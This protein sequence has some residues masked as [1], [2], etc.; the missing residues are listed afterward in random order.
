VRYDPATVPTRLAQLRSLAGL[1]AG[2]AKALAV[3]GSGRAYPRVDGG[4]EV[5]GL[6][7]RATIT[8]DRFG[9]PHVEAASEADAIFGQGFVQAQDRLFQLEL[10]R[11]AAA[12]RLAEVLGPSAL[13]PDRFMR[14]LGIAG[15]AADDLTSSSAEE[16][17]LLDAFAAGVNAAVATRRA[18]P[19]EFAVLGVAPEPWRPEHS[20]LVGRLLMLG[21]AMNWDGELERDR[22][23]A[24]LGPE[25]A[26]LVDA[27]YRPDAATT[28]GDPNEGAAE[29]LLVAYR[30]VASA[31]VLAGGASNAWAVTGEHTRSG[32]PLLACDP[33]LRAG[34]PGLFHVAHLVGGELDVI[35]AGVP[36]LPGV[37]IGHNR[38]VAW[39]V[40]AGLADVSD[41]YIEEID[42]DDP[43]RYRT[44]GGWERARTRVERIEVRGASAVE[45][46]VIET[47]HGAVIG[48]AIPGEERAIALR[49]TALEDGEMAAPLLDANRARDAAEFDAAIA[50]WPG[51][52]FNFVFAD[53]E[54]SIGYR[55]GG[56]IPRRERGEG[57]LPQDGAR[58]PGPRE[59]LATEEMPQLR[60]P[61]CGVVVSANQAPGGPHELGEEW[62]EPYRAERIT[63]LLALRND[64]TVASMQAIQLDLHNAALVA[65]RDL[66]L[67]RDAVEDPEARAILE[68]WEGQSDTASAGAAI[69]QTVYQEAAR[70]LVARVA[71]DAADFVLGKGLGAP[72]GEQSR[73]HYRLQGRIV[74]ALAE[75][76]APWCDDAADRDRVLR[77]AVARAVDELR[78]RLG[79][80]PAAWRWGALREQRRPHPL[81]RVPSLGRAFAVGPFEMPGDINTVW[82]GG[83]AVHAGAA[84]PGGFSPVYRQVLDLG[85][86][87]RSSFQLPAGNSG[88]PGHPHYEDCVDEFLEGRQRPLLYSREAVRVNAAHTLVLDPAGAPS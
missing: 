63:E 65:L 36:G 52:T 53:R 33:H 17:A 8:R 28:T 16:R 58:S 78:E 57:L 83:Y 29:R 80:R 5:D 55:M 45:E 54:G 18:L 48:P 43:A 38:D 2:V 19:P 7:R 69:M 26:A 84:A 59:P 82:Q 73:F 31:G 79:R 15:R 74:A 37:V 34:V 50:R 60:D 24:A 30:G 61:P 42:P 86:W 27:A 6:E 62:T 22:L 20:M 13:E 70:T 40:T 76:G 68:V 11:R 35:G 67:A 81:D 77:A 88:I 3:A 41:C 56:S 10:F 49:S 9:V 75:A 4:L 32:T 72:I 14:R 64:H 21:F 25:R 66:L 39:G 87:D 51:A 46:T 1:G 47:R 23:L 71:G 12:G 85:R 44:P